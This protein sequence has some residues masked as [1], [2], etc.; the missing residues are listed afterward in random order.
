MWPRVSVVLIVLFDLLEKQNVIHKGLDLVMPHQ[1]RASAVSAWV[2][3]VSSR[4]RGKGGMKENDSNTDHHVTTTVRDLHRVL[5]VARCGSGSWYTIPP[6]PRY[7]RTNVAGGPSRKSE[8]SF[9]L[10]HPQC[11]VMPALC[12][13]TAFSLQPL[14]MHMQD[15]TTRHDA[16]QQICRT[17]MFQRRRDPR[18]PGVGGKL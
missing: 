12:T 15:D 14:I 1:I 3:L 4:S 16:P 8:V 6:P 17:S 10:P 11:V 2:R 13:I 5:P 18:G 9:L 7:H